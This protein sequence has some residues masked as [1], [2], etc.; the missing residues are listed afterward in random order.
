MQIRDHLN[1]CCERRREHQAHPPPQPAPEENPNRRRHWPDTHA[2]GNKFR[3]KKVRGHDMQEENS[4]SDDNVWSRGVELKQGRCKE[5][6]QA[7]RSIREMA[8]DS[9]AR[10]RFRE[11]RHLSY[12]HPTTPAW[13]PRP[14]RSRR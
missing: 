8:A 11:V 14:S 2:I 1:E 4:Q 9:G 13:S 7:K 12:Q 5:E 3:N 10:S 6:V